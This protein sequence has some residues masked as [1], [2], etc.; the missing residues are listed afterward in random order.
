MEIDFLVRERGKIRPSL[1]FRDVYIS[2]HVYIPHPVF[3]TLLFFSFINLFFFL[4]SRYF[5]SHFLFQN[6]LFYPTC[7]LVSL[8]KSNFTFKIPLLP[9][10]FNNIYINISPNPAKK[11]LKKR[12]KNAALDSTR[13]RHIFKNSKTNCWHHLV[14]W[15]TI[16][17]YYV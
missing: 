13:L 12:I 7:L 5:P 11:V 15:S 10:N 2:L 14:L 4:D 8:P 1:C 6:N 16:Y 17:D 9:Y 3:V